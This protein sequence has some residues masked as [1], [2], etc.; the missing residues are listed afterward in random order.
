MKILEEKAAGTLTVKEIAAIHGMHPCN[1]HR[2]QKTM[3]Q[4]GEAALQDKPPVPKRQPELTPQTVQQRVV[5]VKNAHPTLG[6][7]KLQE[8]KLSGRYT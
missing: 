2:W 5:E 6:S 4:G 1:I 7:R 3:K 8:L